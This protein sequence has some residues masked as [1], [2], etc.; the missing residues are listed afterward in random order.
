MSPILIACGAF[1]LAVLWKD[2]MFDVQVLRHRGDP[3]LPEAVLASIAAY[4]R[5][6]TT[7]AW[8]MNRVIGLVMVIALV[9]LLVQLLRPTTAP[10]V[11]FPSL[12]LCG[13]P[14]LLVPRV[15]RHAVRL[16]ARSD[17]AAMQSAL[18]RSICRDH[19]ICLAGIAAFLAL[20][21][22]AW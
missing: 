2:L 10:W 9:S 13:G 15:F 14:V 3:E 19:L 8:P 12:P 7:D 17:T 21:L 11:A 22:S 4:Y 18:A 6:V 5:R 20:Q 16:G 1:L